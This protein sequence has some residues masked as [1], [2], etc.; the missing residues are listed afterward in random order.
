MVI[1][2]RDRRAFKLDQFDNWSLMKIGQS[3]LPWYTRWFR[4]G[5]GK[6]VTLP[7]GACFVDYMTDSEHL[8]LVEIRNSSTDKEFSDLVEHLVYDVWV[9]RSVKE[10]AKRRLS[11]QVL[12][13]TGRQIPN[14]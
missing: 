10:R 2:A 3:D 4:I 12:M 11:G 7:H 1:Y 5:L 13:E 6:Y 14:D 8:L 9:R